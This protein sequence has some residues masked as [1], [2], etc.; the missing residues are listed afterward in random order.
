MCDSHVCIKLSEIDH[1][2][3]FLSALDYYLLRA[4]LRLVFSS[5]RSTPTAKPARISHRHHLCWFLQNSQPQSEP[6]TSPP[7]RWGKEVRRWLLLSR[8]Y[9]VNSNS[10]FKNAL[11]EMR[12]TFRLEVSVPDL[13]FNSV[14]YFNSIER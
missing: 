9:N 6:W 1:A 2:I 14:F 8:R 13:F 3:P 12:L 4:G 5:S 10:K 11:F 7:L